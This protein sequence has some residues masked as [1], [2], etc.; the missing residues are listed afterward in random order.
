MSQLLRTSLIRDRVSVMT[1]TSH[2][3]AVAGE[4][5]AAIARKGVT[6]SEV[7]QLVGMSSTSMSR[8][9][10]GANAL[11]VDELIAIA[12]ALDVSPSSLIPTA[13]SVAA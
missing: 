2:R 4:V 12:N 7:A 8:K 5:R 9:L 1:Y 10:A 3:E 11:T 13:H 6:Q